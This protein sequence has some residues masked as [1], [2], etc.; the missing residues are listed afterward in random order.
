MADLKA[1]KNQFMALQKNKSSFKLS[2]RTVVEIVMKIKNRGKVNLLH[3]TSGKEYVV[4]G[5]ANIEIV[6]EIKK[7]KRVTTFELS[8]YL[9]L[10]I[11][12]IEK[13]V[14]DLIKKNKNY[15]LI[16]GKIMTKEYLD[17]ITEEINEEVNKQGSSSLAEISNKYDL[18]IDFL[19]NFL[20]EKINDGILKAK[21]FPTRIITDYYIQ[22]QLKKIRPILLANVNP[23]SISK[24]LSKYPDIDDLLIDQNINTLIDLG[25]VKGSFISNQF[26]NILY[27]KAQ[28]NYVIG[29]LNRNN[30][31]DYAK[32]K[33]IGINKNG[34][35][36]VKNIIKKEPNIKGTFLKDYFISDNLKNNIYLIITDNEGKNLPTNLK[37]NELLV[38]LDEDDIKILLDS[39]E[40]NNE[41]YIYSNYNYIPIKLINEFTENKKNEIKLIAE[42]LFNICVKKLK[43][44]KKDEEEQKHEDNIQQDIQPGPG[45]KKKKKGGGKSSK[46]G[47]NKKNV[48]ENKNKIFLEIKLPKKDI[49]KISEDFMNNP[50]FEFINEKRDCLKDIFEENILPELKS[51]FDLEI[52]AL[53]KLKEKQDN[54]VDINSH[55]KL[56]NNS[57]SYLKLI[58]NNISKV[59]NHFKSNEEKRALNALTTHLCKHEL[60]IFMKDLMIYEIAKNKLT[61][62][63]H[64][65]NTF[66]ERE[67]VMILFNDHET[68]T[69][70][71][72]L[73]KIVNEKNLNK[74]MDLLDEFI[75][76]KKIEI[77]YDGNKEKEQIN[78]IESD[79]NKIIK[80]YNL[81]KNKKLDYKSFFKHLINIFN[82]AFVKKNLYF[83]LP[84]EFWIFSVCN[85]ILNID[86]FKQNDD[87]NYAFNEFYKM[88]ENKKENAFETIFNDNKEKLLELEEQFKSDIN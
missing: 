55:L 62:D 72:D 54:Q 13:K 9:E 4:D 16:D 22:N 18:S 17:K 36:F 25:Q 57:Y 84:N 29:E 56:L 75:K 43:E 40:L 87:F 41:D 19:K 34:E 46:S 63:I 47:G 8:S 82:L 83:K 64:K 77:N 5:K 26:E 20:K 27:S 59:E 42:E 3:T 81:D 80:E 71:I 51:I 38:N 39:I 44:E 10:P 12:I 1:L 24:I 35:E 66:S 2:E 31:I 11:S 48:N 6:N 73:N 61:I 21:L 79:L 88:I 58:K 33:N 69:Y 52:R 86:L 67:Q 37:E 85:A 23:I 45:D 49:D 32:L 76:E 74:F 70:F 78:K 30:Y 65:L 50:S 60:N 7:R 28:E 68:K 15:L 53:I 14:D